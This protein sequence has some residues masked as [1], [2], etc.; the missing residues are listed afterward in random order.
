[1]P[2]N[3]YALQA[4][5]VCDRISVYIECVD[6]NMER[7][8]NMFLEH[9]IKIHKIINTFKHVVSV[10]LVIDLKHNLYILKSY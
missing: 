5:D 4:Y 2:P 7:V 8:N 3:I 1:M 6:G 9:P 10:W